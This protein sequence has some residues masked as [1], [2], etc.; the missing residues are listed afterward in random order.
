MSAARTSS[1]SQ[2]RNSVA[3]VRDFKLL[4]RPLPTARAARRMDRVPTEGT[5]PR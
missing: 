4:S 2:I 3:T 5:D 1:A